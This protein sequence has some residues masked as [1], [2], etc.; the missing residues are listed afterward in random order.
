MTLVEYGRM[1]SAAVRG[2]PIAAGG[3]SNVQTS[4]AEQLP[5]SKVGQTLH[6]TMGRAVKQA[7]VQNALMAGH[8][9]LE[10]IFVSYV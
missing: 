1:I 2:S 5:T 10:V 4:T 6:W 8:F 9:G 7:N 3:F